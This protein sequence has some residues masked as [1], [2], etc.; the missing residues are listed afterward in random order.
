MNNNIEEDGK[1]IKVTMEDIAKNNNRIGF[2][3]YEKND[4]KARDITI[5]ADDNSKLIERLQN[6]NNNNEKEINNLIVK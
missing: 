1:L 3:M 5:I 2:K 6:I 4:E